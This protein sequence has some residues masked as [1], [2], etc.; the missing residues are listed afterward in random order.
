[1]ISELPKNQKMSIIIRV[2]NTELPI[3]HWTNDPDVGGGRIV[4]DACHFIDLSMFL[5]KS[6][7]KSISAESIKDVDNLNNTVVINLKFKNGSIASINYFSNGN[8]KS[9]KRV[10]RSLL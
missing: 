7:I 3:D 4:S 10:Y 2:N 5:T 1:M 8:K 9:F 6:N